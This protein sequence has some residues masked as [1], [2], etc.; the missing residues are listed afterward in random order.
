MPNSFWGLAR[1][2]LR[3]NLKRNL[4]TGSAIAFG[5]AGI[6][7]LGAYSNR[8]DN[9]IRVY[10]IY[11]AHT[12]HVAL[13]AKN[14]LDKFGFEPKKHSFSKQ[15]Q[16][17][18]EGLLKNDSR[19]E[20]FEPRFSGVGLISNGCKSIPFSAVGIDPQ[21]EEKLMIHPEVKRWTPQIESI[22]KGVKLVDAVKISSVAVV[23]ITQKVASALGKEKVKTEFDTGAAV[24]VVDCESSVA[25]PQSDASVQFLGNSWQG[26]MAALDADVV[27]IFSTGFDETDFS[28][29]RMPLSVLQSF[30]DTERV[31]GYSVW[32]KEASQLKSFI[33]TFSAALNGPSLAPEPIDLIPWYD[34]SLSPYYAGTIQ[35]LNAMVGF[36]SS[37]LALVVL[38]SVLNSTTLTVLERTSEIGMYRSIGFRKR[39]IQTLFIQESIW[40][41]GFSLGIGL[42]S[43]F[44]FVEM[45]NRM[46]IVYHPPGASGGL[47]LVL[48][49]NVSAIFVW[50]VVLLLLTIWSTRFSVVNK[51]KWQI[52]D[53]LG[54]S[55]R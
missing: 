2:N 9:Y 20:M 7:L 24:K 13:F 5:F 41:S 40:L 8:V 10:T 48:V 46:K 17:E 54:G 14:G 47:Q 31:A 32:L 34:E 52:S 53:L 39:Q 28:A 6:I 51:L 30:Y 3:R 1:K 43:G 36:V 33:Q 18:I 4:T 15:R 25:L 26:G 35:F 19:V 21:I 27:S 37:V 49:A 12:G 44:V 42:I 55:G 29:I 38:F 50:A 22:K 11:A 16:L 23:S 45:I